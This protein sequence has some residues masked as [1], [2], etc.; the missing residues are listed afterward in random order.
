MKKK[1]H[2]WL[3]FLLFV[4]IGLGIFMIFRQEMTPGQSA[5]APAPETA[6][7]SYSPTPSPTPTPEPTEVPTMPPTPSPT[8][9]PTPSP[10]P[11]P[12]P[13]P[14]S[15]ATATPEA[16]TAVILTD[17]SGS[18]RTNTG[19]FLNMIVKYTIR[20]EGSKTFLAL[21]AYSESYGLETGRNKDDLR[22]KVGN[23][24]YHFTTGPI[25]VTE[26]H[27]LTETLLGSVEVEVQSGTEVDVSA[28]W[29]FNGVISDREL[30][31]LTAHSVIAIP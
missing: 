12:T 2:G 30:E 10:V 24:S 6:A 4:V 21:D 9:I 22:I 29:Y 17:A 7:P 27:F 18:F 3:L 28:D 1:S 25:L 19:T 11:T 8:P 31:T 14:A 20:Q 15:A 5:P 26:N 23:E 16:A 13:T